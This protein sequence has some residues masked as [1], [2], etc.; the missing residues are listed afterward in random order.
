M[1]KDPWQCIIKN[2]VSNGEIDSSE[3]NRGFC[4]FHENNVLVENLSLIHEN[5]QYDPQIQHLHSYTIP[6]PP[7]FLSIP[8]S[9]NTSKISQRTS[10]ILPSPK[11]ETSNDDPNA[12]DI[13]I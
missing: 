9:N 11:E 1:I 13:D 10:I 5:K 4:N 8:Q 12:I 3:L 7:P 6:P 2:K